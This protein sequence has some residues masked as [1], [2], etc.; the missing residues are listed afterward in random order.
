M[1]NFKFNKK[2]R[3][4]YRDRKEGG[5]CIRCGNLAEYSE[6]TGDFKTLCDKCNIRAKKHY[7]RFSTQGLC[8]K[9]GAEPDINP[10]TNKRFFYCKPCRDKYNAF[11]RKHRSSGYN[12]EIKVKSKRFLKGIKGC[13]SSLNKNQDAGST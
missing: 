11:M 12:D 5:F 13:Q 6:K 10:K 7:N 8:G 2:R 9:C 3:K 4:Q 1:T